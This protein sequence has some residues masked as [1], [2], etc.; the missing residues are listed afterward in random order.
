MTRLTPVTHADLV[1]G[2]RRHGFTGPFAGGKHFY[3]VKGDLRLTLPNPHRGDISPD[4]LARI[5]RQAGTD[6][7]QWVGG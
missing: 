7:G 2:L 5:L 3:M 1:A 6:R 4:L